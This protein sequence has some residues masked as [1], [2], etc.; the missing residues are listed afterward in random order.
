MWQGKVIEGM[1]DEARMVKD[2]RLRKCCRWGQ[3]AASIAS[4]RVPSSIIKTTAMFVPSI[5][6][7]LKRW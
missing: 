2:D 5:V 7:L 6:E 1:T 4:G 3:F